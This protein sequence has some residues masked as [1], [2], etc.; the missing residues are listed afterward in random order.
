MYKYG[1]CLCIPFIQA[2]TVRE[3]IDYIKVCYYNSVETR[4]AAVV[5]MQFSIVMVN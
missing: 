2:K 3:F 5:L 1:F 4:H